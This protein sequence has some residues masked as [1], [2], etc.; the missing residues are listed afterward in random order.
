MSLKRRLNKIEYLL[1]ENKNSAP[2]VIIYKDEA[3]QEIKLREHR[4]KYGERRM[5]I[6]LPE[7]SNK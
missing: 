5:V 6:F 7:K 4:E 1:G 2:L 3:D